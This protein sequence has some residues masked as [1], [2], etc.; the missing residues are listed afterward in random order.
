MTVRRL[1]LIQPQSFAFTAENLRFAEAA[2]KKYPPGKQASAVLPILWRAQEQN[3]GWV[4][5]PAMEQVAEMLGLAF[6]RVY[7]IATFYS[8]FQLSPV[9]SRAHVQVCGTTPCMLRGAE[10]L[11]EAC[12]RRIHPE[13]HHLSDDGAFSWEEVECLGACVNAPMVQIWKDTFEDLTPETFERVLAGF[14]AGAPPKPGP[15][16]GRQFS[17]PE[18]PLT[19]LT[20]AS[21]Y[22]KGRAFPPK[23]EPEGEVA[24]AP[25]TL[26]AGQPVQH[27][28]AQKGLTQAPPQDS[29]PALFKEPRQGQPDDLKIIKGIGPKL[30]A[31][32][33]EMGIWHFD[34]IAAWTETELAWVDARLGDFKGRARRDGWVRQAKRLAQ[35]GGR[36]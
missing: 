32:L 17:A 36:D 31:M 23:P 27:A 10:E 26:A 29:A 3:G 33:H 7:E 15:Q 25:E 8:M 24:A 21:L 30:E 19:S 12:R 6:I 22:D 5:R 20:D 18:G 35:A 34:Q 28:E 4:S 13:P 16:N 1:D 9:G 14:A 2:V 11:K